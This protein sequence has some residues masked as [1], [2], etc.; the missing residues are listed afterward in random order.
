MREQKPIRLLDSVYN[1]IWSWFL[2]FALTAV[3]LSKGNLSEKALAISDLCKYMIMLLSFIILTWRIIIIV[4][5][6]IKNKVI[7]DCEVR[8]DDIRYVYDLR[9]RILDDW[10]AVNKMKLSP[11]IEKH[12]KIELLTDC[13]DGEEKIINFYKLLHLNLVIP[14]PTGRFFKIILIKNF[15][16]LLLWG[17]MLYTVLIRVINPLPALLIL[18]A[19]QFFSSAVNRRTLYYLLYFAFRYAT[20][21]LIYY[22][23]IFGSRLKNIAA[24]SLMKEERKHSEP[25]ETVIAEEPGGLIQTNE[26]LD[27]I[28]NLMETNP[29]KARIGKDKLQRDLNM[30]LKHIGM[31][32]QA[33]ELEVYNSWSSFG[34]NIVT[35]NTMSV[36]G[37]TLDKLENKKSE[38]SNFLGWNGLAFERGGNIGHVNII[39]PHS[40]R[41][42]I[43]LRDM[44]TSKQY[45]AI[46]LEDYPIPL[47]ISLDGTPVYAQLGMAITPHI[48]IGGGT[49][50]GKSY[51]VNC[52]LFSL[53]NAYTP[54]D[55]LLAIIDPKGTE[56]ANYKTYPH[57]LKFA[58]NKFEEQ[59]KLVS[60]AENE[61]NRRNINVFEP[62]NVRNIKQYNRKYPEEKLPRILVLIDEYADIVTDKEQRK[63]FE[64]I[65]MRLAAKARSAGIHLCLMMQKPNVETI[66]SALRSNL[67]CR[68][69]LRMDNANSYKTVLSNYD[70]TELAGNGDMIV[71]FGGNRYRL[72][73]PCLTEGD[74][75]DEERLIKKCSKRW[76]PWMQD[77]KITE[78]TPEDPCDTETE[79][80]EN[81]SGQQ[82]RNYTEELKAY[83]INLS[84]EGNSHLPG[85]NKLAAALHCDIRK[86]RQAITDLREI[87][88][89]RE[90]GRPGLGDEIVTSGFPKSNVTV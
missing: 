75:E 49:G 38:I 58:D 71:E 1:G 87:G 77:V 30:C 48:L 53:V 43:L 68:V 4:K 61:M 5:E 78:P 27:E 84:Q 24:R 60:W 47:G 36:P 85:Q 6:F 82:V 83:V 18:F 42:R 22:T 86:I 70:G 26:V 31:L 56:F 2:Y 79:N 34:A 14:Y 8:D 39:V 12:K 16:V 64:P 90:S 20:L 19:H 21:Y 81:I 54:R 52:M 76:Q 63:Q 62:R 7:G 29:L 66:N 65:I 25:I 17:W 74:E 40:A 46:A 50:S 55:F 33:Q 35:V 44:L 9:K 89:I 72:Q 11:R 88:I 23:G 15:N 73:G 32:N 80:P 10:I 67:G 37:L 28:L 57:L 3:F 41:E 69:A 13:Q 59:L 45:N 51:L